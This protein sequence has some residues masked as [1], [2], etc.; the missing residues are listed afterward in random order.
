MTDLCERFEYFKAI[1]YI[2]EIVLVIQIS[3]C[4]TRIED[5]ERRKLWW[6]FFPL[7]PSYFLVNSINRNFERRLSSGKLALGWIGSD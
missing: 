5:R 1:R 6:S 4:A 7:V 3:T 2:G